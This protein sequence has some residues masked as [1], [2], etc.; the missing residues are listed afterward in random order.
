CSARLPRCDTTL[1]AGERWGI[2]LAGLS[3]SPARLQKLNAGVGWGALNRS[4]SFC[5]SC[6]N[7]ANS[8][9]SRDRMGR[10]RT[11]RSHL[12]GLANTRGAAA[13]GRGSMIRKLRV[14]GFTLI[15]LLVVI[16]IIA[17]LAAIL[18]PVFAQAREKARSASCQSN[19]K[20][21]ATGFMQ[22]IQD[23]DERFPSYNWG[24]AVS[25]PWWYSIQ[26]Y[27]KNYK[28]LECPSNAGINPSLN[29]NQLTAQRDNNG[30]Q[31]TQRNLWLSISNPP[32]LISYGMS[33]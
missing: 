24:R 17:I 10:E 1:Q 2:A 3:P 30:N 27:V 21:L 18:F 9:S 7:A 29:N 12:P 33:E 6:R 26:P 25:D 28:V 8:T 13:R 20:Q 14:K 15:E 16:A 4:R 32:P 23:Y 11:P 19:L 5:I 22:Y 31:L